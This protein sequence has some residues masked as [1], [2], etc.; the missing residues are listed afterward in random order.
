[1]SSEKSIAALRADLDATADLKLEDAIP[2]VATAL[3]GRQLFIPLDSY[4]QETGE[5]QLLTG[6]DVDGNV[7]IY[8]YTGK[9]LLD[10]KGLTGTLCGEFEF[11]EIIRMAQKGPFAGI[12]ID[13]GGTSTRAFIPDYWLAE[14]ERVLGGG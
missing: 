7:W 8:A 12:A 10:E 6:K 5:L 1:M 13:G 2:I 14:I 9:D 11:L 4:D 3:N